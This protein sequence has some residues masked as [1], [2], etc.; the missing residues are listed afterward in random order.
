MRLAFILSICVV[1]AVS[2]LNRWAARE[3]DHD[4]LGPR[5]SAKLSAAAM[6]NAKEGT[7]LHVLSLEDKLSGRA[8][9]S[10]VSGRI[11]AD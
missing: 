2:Y 11:R 1:P 5:S 3:C 8:R 10:D 4:C 6:A 9:L 7:R